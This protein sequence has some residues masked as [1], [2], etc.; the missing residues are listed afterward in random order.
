MTFLTV[1]TDNYPSLPCTNH[2][3]T[4]CNV[5]LQNRDKFN[6]GSRQRTDYKCLLRNH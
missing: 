2:V 4:H 3:E 5:S 6:H 1:E